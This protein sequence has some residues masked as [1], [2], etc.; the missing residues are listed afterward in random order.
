MARFDGPK[1]SCKNQV[2]FVTF[3]L[4]GDSAT[5]NWC[6]I[7]VLGDLFQIVS[8]LLCVPGSGELSRM[9]KPNGFG[10]RK[11]GRNFPFFKYLSD[12]LQIDHEKKSGH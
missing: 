11:I 3:A 9:Q 12:Y 1:Y 6:Q 5:F 2:T 7:E 8:K 4:V 10:K